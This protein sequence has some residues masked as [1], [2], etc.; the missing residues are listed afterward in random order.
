MNRRQFLKRSAAAVAG[1]V[2][3]RAV[4]SVWAQPQN[5]NSDVRVAVIGVGNQG[6]RHAERFSRLPGV[7]LVA[8]CDVDPKRVAASVEKLKA[9]GT[10]PDSATDPRR[11]LER[12]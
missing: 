2:A 4:P 7:R 10:S 3:A 9:A 1:G 11:I 6:G 8:V 12:N 5:A